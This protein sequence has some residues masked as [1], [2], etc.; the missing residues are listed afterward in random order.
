MVLREKGTDLRVYTAE[1]VVKLTYFT[2]YDYL[3][4]IKRVS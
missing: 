4:W 1:V 3:E 2:C